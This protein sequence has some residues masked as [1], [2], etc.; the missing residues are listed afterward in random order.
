MTLLSCSAPRGAGQSVAPKRR[1]GTGSERAGRGVL[2]GGR[3][4]A[5][6]PWEAGPRMTQWLRARSL[7]VRILVYAA[8]ATLVFVLAAGVGAVGALALRGDVVG[9][10]E[11]GQARPTA[12]WGD[13]RTGRARAAGRPRAAA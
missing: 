13:A 6:H 4:R 3:V 2:G 10:L 11:G 5:G 12:G 7:P 9:L 8:L 1:K